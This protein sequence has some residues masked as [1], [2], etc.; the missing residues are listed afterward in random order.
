MKKIFLLLALIASPAWG[1][2]YEPSSYDDRY[3]QQL[4]QADE[5]A[6]N[7]S[8]ALTAESR[9]DSMQAQLDAQQRQIDDQKSRLNRY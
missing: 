4:T 9:M 1:Q 5:D 3:I 8:S 6:R 7:E 2:S